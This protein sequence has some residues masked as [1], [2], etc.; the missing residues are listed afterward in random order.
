MLQ[1]FLLLGVGRGVWQATQQEAILIPAWSSIQRAN[2]ANNNITAIDE[3]M[4][5]PY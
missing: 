1:E 3:S 2:F 5:S 4:V